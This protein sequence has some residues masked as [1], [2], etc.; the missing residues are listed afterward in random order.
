MASPGEGDGDA[1]RFVE[2]G[3]PAWDEA[4]ARVPHDVYHLPGYARVEAEVQD[5]TPVAFLHTGARHTFLL[6][7]L[8]RPVPGATGLEALSPYGY[9]GPV[10]D[11]PLDDDASW[12]EAV[13]SLHDCL[14]SRGVVTCFVRLHPLLPGRLDALARAGTVVQHGH[15]VSID[16]TVPGEVLWARTRSNHRRNIEQARRSGLRV[17]IDDWSR[18]PE[19]VEAYHETMRRVGATES[20]FFPPAYFE[21]LR[22]HVAGSVHLAVVDDGGTL[23]GGGIF[24]EQDVIVQ[25]HLGATRSVYLPRQPTKLLFD[26][27]RRWAAE[28]GDWAFHLGGGVG[29]RVNPL[30]HFKAGFS[31]D[32]PPFFTWR[33]VPDP[34][35]YA[36][37]VETARRE[38]PPDDSGWFPAYRG[39]GAAA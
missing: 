34:D 36:A 35:G 10:S 19:F 27:V 3:D 17:V 28:R 13:Q 20:Y 24:F 37:A 31:D 33:L 25:Y 18:L 11:A 32:R 39:P 21:S 2:A 8:L 14:R 22:K 38:L 9:P 23:A 6:P 30:F 16:L 26:E 29:G 5:A 12:R 7:L 4:L 1:G 15:T